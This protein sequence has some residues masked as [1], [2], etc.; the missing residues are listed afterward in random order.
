M[1]PVR[2]LLAATLAVFVTFGGV[3]WERAAASRVFAPQG[4]VPRFQVDPFWPKPLP[5]K[6]M[7]GQ[8]GGTFVDSRDHLWITTR[9]RSL[10]DN[11]KYAELTPPQADCCVPPPPVLEFDPAGNL[12]Q[13]WGGPGADYDWVDN[14][15]GIFVDHKDNVW[16]TGN[17]AKDTNILK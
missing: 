13:G 10:D 9:P 17:G 6:W 16:I 2:T 12:I 1:H 11:D 4:A 8:I 3:L 14:E 15:H 5:N 7:L